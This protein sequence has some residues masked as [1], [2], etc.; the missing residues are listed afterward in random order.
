MKYAK[1]IQEKLNEIA[2]LNIKKNALE[3]RENEYHNEI[4]EL[5][6]TVKMECEER[7]SLLFSIEEYKK[8]I[9]KLNM[10]KNI[11]NNNNMYEDLKNKPFESND[12]EE[13]LKIKNSS[14]K[15]LLKKKPKS[16]SKANKSVKNLKKHNWSSLYNEN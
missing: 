12:N 2:D 6:E 3:K 9:E 13:T 16:S 8:K 5:K 11:L 15:S 4:S 14:S 7:L 10:K 1:E